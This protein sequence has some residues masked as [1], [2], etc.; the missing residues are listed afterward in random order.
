M[1][2]FYVW[3]YEQLKKVDLLYDNWNGK[4]YL[5]GSGWII[6][7]IPSYIKKDINT[8]LTNGGPVAS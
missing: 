4:P 2:S 7:K 6:N 8:L 5:Y 3:E 1:Q